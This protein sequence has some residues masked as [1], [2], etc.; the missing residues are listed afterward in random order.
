MYDLKFNPEN[1][2][3]KRCELDGR[4]VIYRAFENIVYC[5]NPVSAVQ[6]LNLYVPEVYYQ[7]ESINGYQLHTAPI[8]APNT[9]GGYMEG[10]AMQVGEDYFGHKPNTAFEALYHGYV[11]GFGDEIPVESPTNFLW[12]VRMMRSPRKKVCLR[13]ALRH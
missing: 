13:D 4:E 10:P 1:Y 6:K 11:L 3:I 2:Q 7:G 5:A 12:A 8:F 9:V